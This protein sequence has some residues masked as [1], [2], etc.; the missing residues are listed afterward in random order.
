LGDLKQIWSWNKNA[1]DDVSDQTIHGLFAQ[2]AASQPE[3]PAVC[4]WD[5]EFTYKEVDEMST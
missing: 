2:I 3:A 4:S 1:L 5:G